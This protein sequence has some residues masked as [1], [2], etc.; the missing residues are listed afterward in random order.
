MARYWDGRAWSATTMPAPS[1]VPAPVA[2]RTVVT[3][4]PRRGGWG[5]V[6]AALAVVLVGVLVG[7]GFLIARTTGPASD[8][9]GTDPASAGP[10]CPQ[11]TAASSTAAPDSGDRV[12]SGRLSYPRLGSP[13]T[14]P[15]SDART[16]F[17][18]DVR[19]QLATV[20]QVPGQ[21]LWVAQ[22]LI[23]RLLAGDGFY[24]PRQ[25]AA[26]VAQCVIGT[27]YWDYPVG[28]EDRRNEA[29]TV[30]GRDAWLVEMH[31]SFDIPD[32]KTRGEVATIVVV[33]AGD[34]EAGLFYSSIPDTSP[35]FAAPAREA[36]EGLRVR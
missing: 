19:T 22:V 5:W 24:G 36:L 11:A 34:G 6:L 8:D 16:P 12:V 20:E 27:F 30:D 15:Q 10:V 13:F 21:G 18:R 32:L 31:L 9:P 25:G 3:P 1:G 14:P 17:G 26:I 4:P 23:A 29:T 2:P 28:R 35:Q 33:D 7:V